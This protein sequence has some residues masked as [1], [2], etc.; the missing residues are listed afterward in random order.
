MAGT[1]AGIL[2]Q[3]GSLAG[4][5]PTNIDL[6]AVPNIGTLARLRRGA[7]HAHAQAVFVMR[8]ELAGPQIDE[9]IGRVEHPR[10]TVKGLDRHGDHTIRARNALDTRDR[11]RRADRTLDRRR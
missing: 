10:V 4:T 2:N 7:S 6:S 1:G 8:Q 5:L 3:V 11:A 9:P